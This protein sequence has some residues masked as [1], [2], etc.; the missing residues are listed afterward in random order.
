MRPTNLGDTMPKCY[1]PV[2]KVKILTLSMVCFHLIFR[3]RHGDPPH[4]DP[5]AYWLP[6]TWARPGWRGAGPE[7]P[8]AAFCHVEEWRGPGE[9]L[10][11]GTGRTRGVEENII[12]NP[13]CRPKHGISCW[14][15]GVKIQTGY[16]GPGC[17]N[18]IG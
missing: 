10:H 13:L 16:I 12:K 6:I 18:R 3:S 11:Q 1:R 2:C 14:T 15:L 7:S 4:P 9:W 17:R 5:S 8:G